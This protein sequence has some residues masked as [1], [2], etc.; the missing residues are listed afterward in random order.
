MKLKAPLDIQIEVTSNC[1]YDCGYCY[2][3]FE[4][5]SISMG[6][7]QLR[8]I[9]NEL[10]ANEVFSLIFTGGE[11]FM[12]RKILIKGLILAQEKGRNTYLNTNLSIPLLNEEIEVLKG[13]QNV[14]FSFP[15]AN[16]DK[17]TKITGAEKF[18]SVLK[19][20]E[21]LSSQ[22]VI[23]T[24]NQVITQEN[25]D[26]IYKTARFLKNSFGINNFCATPVN[27]F[28]TICYP[29]NLSKDDY[30]KIARELVN[31]ENKLEM[32][33]E[34]LTCLPL[35][36]FPEDLRGNKLLKKGCS[37]GISTGAIGA[38]GDV[39]KCVETKKVYGNIF[40]EPFLNIWNKIISE[41]TSNYERC[42]GCSVQIECSGDCEARRIRNNNIDPLVSEIITD[43]PRSE[44]EELKENR[45]YRIKKFMIRKERE[46][47]YIITDGGS[48]LISGNG[49]FV[50]LLEK[51][52]KKS[53]HLNQIK[54]TLGE[55]G[56]GI[57][58]Y[59]NS[60]GMIEQNE[61]N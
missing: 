47:E 14:L 35:C 22:G 9:I 4:H 40:K 37:A 20:L 17:Y 12:N 36:I 29:Y 58:R 46:E 5:K 38:E 16:S 30:G 10:D 7:F 43:Y 21:N 33:V 51:L 8:H 11:P 6:E 31:V 57:I 50:G 39:R 54:S 45:R 60:Q 34:M 56:M 28:G 24:A 48:F 19:N 49:L 52:K 18:K 59:L 1:N 42:N 2:N 55:R 3:P 41:E 13:V 27:P 53:F 26:E 25:K 15:S 32:K 44:I 23:L 61:N